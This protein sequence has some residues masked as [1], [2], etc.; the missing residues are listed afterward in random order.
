ME[1]KEFTS[2]VFVKTEVEEGDCHYP[3]ITNSG[4]PYKSK[5]FP[6]TGSGYF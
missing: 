1:W 4:F 6:L 5:K 2:F 3:A